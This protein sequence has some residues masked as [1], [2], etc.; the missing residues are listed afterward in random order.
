MARRA[1]RPRQSRLVEL[2]LWFSLA[3][4]AV[5]VA[6]WVRMPDVERG[7]RTLVDDLAARWGYQDP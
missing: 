1:A 6:A 2:G 5:L 7:V 4:V 3:F